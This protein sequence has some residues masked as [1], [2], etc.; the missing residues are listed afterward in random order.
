VGL[1]LGLLVRAVRIYRVGSEP[2]AARAWGKS[3]F[4]Y[5]LVYLTGLF[6]G[7]GL[8]RLLAR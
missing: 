3:L 8:D 1:G 7:L 5:S 4:L 6:A 2:E